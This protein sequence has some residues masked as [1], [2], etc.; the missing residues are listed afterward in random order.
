MRKQVP[1]V[2]LLSVACSSHASDAPSPSGETVSG[3]EAPRSSPGSTGGRAAHPTHAATG[4]PSGTPATEVRIHIGTKLV[5]VDGREP[6]SG[7]GVGDRLQKLDGVY[8]ALV[9]VRAAGAPPL[10]IEGEPD[11]PGF[12]VGSVLATAAF[13][14]YGTAS[15]QTARR[16]VGVALTSTGTCVPAELVDALVVKLHR[17]DGGGASLTWVNGW[18]REQ[19]F[20]QVPL[21]CRPFGRECVRRITPLEDALEHAA[22]ER[23][24]ATT[25]SGGR[26]QAVVVGAANEETFGRL[27]ALLDALA[28]AGVERIAVEGA[29]RAAPRELAPPACTP[30]L[31]EREQAAQQKAASCANACLERPAA[32]HGACLERCRAACAQVCADAACR[33]VCDLYAAP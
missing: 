23:E 5:R 29:L 28:D 22:L 25:V 11:A 10:V 26:A 18:G 32:E 6:V 30:D 3:G 8:D 9:A 15:V 4:S 31:P 19:A 33:S 13:A 24:L 17:G 2:V 27:G 12:L 20:P 21:P 7:V 16:R 14:Q 1:L